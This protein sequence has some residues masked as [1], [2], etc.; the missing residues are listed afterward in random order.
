MKTAL[1]WLAVLILLSGRASAI[2][3]VDDDFEAYDD[4]PQ[5]EA[6]WAPIGTTAEV[7]KKS[8]ELDIG[9]GVTPPNTPPD[10][11]RTSIR[12]IGT[13]TDGQFRNQLTFA[14]TPL[15][16]VG[17]QLV[18][19]FDYWDS[20]P[21]LRP[22]NNYATLQTTVDPSGSQV[23]QVL[24][25]GLASNQFADDSGGNFFMASISGHSHAVDDPDGGPDEHV[26]GT[27]SGSF[28]KLNDTGAGSRG[29]EGTPPDWHNLKLIITT[30][31]GSTADHA[32]YVDGV[33]AETV[34][35]VGPLLQY[36]VIRLGSGLANGGRM[37]RF[38]NMR[39]ELVQA[40]AVPE[41][42]AFAA[43]GLV[44]LLSAGAVWLRKR[45]AAT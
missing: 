40:A 11:L 45:R 27:D 1:S 5:F 23:G 28:F 14:P 2:L 36:G 6:V 29:G 16:A 37:V 10:P 13:S 43:V 21:E 20:F 34:S 33:L 38:D 15:L 35:N 18:W 26:N 44:G 41:A 42:G 4:Q 22:F 17:D 8:A 31:D 32:Y 24:S 25:M 39:L 7:S 30:S 12:I 3:V 19:S 9:F